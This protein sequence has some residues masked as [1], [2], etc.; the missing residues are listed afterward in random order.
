MYNSVL[1]WTPSHARDEVRSTTLHPARDSTSGFTPLH[2]HAPSMLHV[3]LTF[4]ISGAGQTSETRGGSLCSLQLE[5]LSLQRQ[6]CPRSS[7][8]RHCEQS[9][10]P[11]A[12]LYTSTKPPE[13]TEN[14]SLRPSQLCTARGSQ[15]HPRC[16]PPPATLIQGRAEIQRMSRAAC[17]Y[18][19]TRQ[20]LA[21]VL[22][23][24]Q[25]DW[26]LLLTAT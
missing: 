22:K 19:R 26:V 13:T 25:K 14:A 8:P 21:A 3:G 24:S 16:P 15:T 12:Q 10:L 20:R 4:L 2:H 11:V 7:L 17:T 18:S 1:L 5:L 23:I 9:A 6:R